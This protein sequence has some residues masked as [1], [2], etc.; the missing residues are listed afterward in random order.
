MLKIKIEARVKCKKHPRYD[1]AKDGLGGIV[2][3][4]FACNRVQSMHQATE[5]F[6][7][8][9]RELFNDPDDGLERLASPA[10]DSVA[11]LA[12]FRYTRLT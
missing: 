12:R 9:M 8:V 7:R 11:A 2:G 5:N 6:A 1:P 4:C 3:G 10:T